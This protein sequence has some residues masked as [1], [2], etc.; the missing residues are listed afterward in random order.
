M[1]DTQLS[2]TASTD[3]LSAVDE[4]ASLRAAK[5]QMLIREQ[6]LCDEITSIATQKG[7]SKIAGVSQVAVIETRKPR[8]L[9]ISK[10]PADVL[11][12]PA[13]F[14]QSPITTCLLYTSP[15]PRDS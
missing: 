2:A 6:E 4:L 5:A 10:L 11:D 3:T 9:D 14:S 7:T 12:N 8:A 13:H 1:T 15:S